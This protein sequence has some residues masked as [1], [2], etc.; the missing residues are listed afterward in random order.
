MNEML[1][2]A[3]AALRSFECV[4][5]RQYW[6]VRDVRE[7][8]PYKV[9]FTCIDL[10]EAQAECDRLNARAVLVAIREPL[11]WMILKA[12]R[13]AEKALGNRDDNLDPHTTWQAM[14]D[15]A[16]DPTSG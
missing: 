8:M 14:I 4:A 11:E 1:D 9:V 2:R 7:Q 13:K 15:A 10:A 5:E 3:I 6:R 16:L 12:D